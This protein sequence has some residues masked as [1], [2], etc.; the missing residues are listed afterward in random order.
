M[1]PKSGSRGKLQ[2]RCCQGLIA[3][4][5]RQ[6][7]IVVPEIEATMPCSTAARAGRGVPAGQRWVGFGRQFAGHRLDGD[8]H[9]R[10]EIGG[11][12]CPGQIGQSGQAFFEE[13]FA[14]LRD[15]LTGGVQ[16]GRDLIVAQPVGGVEHDPGSHD[17][18]IR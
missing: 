14:P 2:D 12:S 17:I 10:G 7:P 5:D 11:S 16:A 3:A 18:A 8:D 6:R 9:V 4:A 1:G 15:H 13:S